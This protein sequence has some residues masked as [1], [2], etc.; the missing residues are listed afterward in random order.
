M[1]TVVLDIEF[2]QLPQEITGL[3]RYDQALILLR[4]RGRPVGQATVPV[5]HGR[6][7]GAE[8]REAVLE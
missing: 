3:D 1:A 6:L 2:E 7:A 5:V 8:L 4:F